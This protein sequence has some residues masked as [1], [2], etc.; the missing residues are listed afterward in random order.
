MAFFL[1]TSAIKIR[2]MNLK[3]AQ[4]GIGS[5]KNLKNLL[6]KNNFAIFARNIFFNSK[7]LLTKKKFCENKYANIFKHSLK[8]GILTFYC[9]DLFLVF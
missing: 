1:K 6:L 7:S 8:F 3:Y 9:E 4:I 2:S 5:V